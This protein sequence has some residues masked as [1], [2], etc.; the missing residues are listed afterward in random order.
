MIKNYSIEVVDGMI[1]TRFS[2][3]AALSDIINAMDDVLTVGVFNKR[4]WV[5]HDG[6]VNLKTG[7]IRKIA[8]H[9]IKIWAAPSKAAIV[10]P[11]SLSF[12]L[13]RMHDAF[14]DEKGGETR[15]FRNEQEA[16]AWLEE[17]DD[18]ATS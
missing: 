13:A 10:V 17:A 12:G 7:E 18:I 15:V 14:R 8:E 1:V 6:L 4:L 9:G 3:K 11:D 5:F 16:I 2:Q